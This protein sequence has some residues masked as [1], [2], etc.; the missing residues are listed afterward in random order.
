LRRVIGRELERID[1]DRLLAVVLTS[2]DID[3][4]LTLAIVYYDD[5]SDN[6]SDVEEALE[7][8]RRALQ[9][10]VNER[11][12]L[13]RTPRLVFRIDPAIETGSRVDE[14]LS[15]LEIPSESHDDPT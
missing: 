14:I 9:S 8:H 5:A 1:D 10:A 3:R 11:T 13:R 6:P 7:Q 2:I 15:G 4:E 12:R